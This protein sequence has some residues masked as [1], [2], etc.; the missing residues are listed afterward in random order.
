LGWTQ[1]RPRFYHAANY[2]SMTS[3]NFWECNVV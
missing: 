3:G 1:L 2:V